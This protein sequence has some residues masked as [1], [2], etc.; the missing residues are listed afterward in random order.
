MRWGGW[1]WLGSPAKLWAA[2]IVF[3]ILGVLLAFGAVGGYAISKDSVTMDLDRPM[4]HIWNACVEETRHQGAVKRLD[5][6]NGRLDAQIQQAS[7]VV[8]VEQL[9]PATVRVVIR[10]R[11]NLLPRIEVAQ[12]LAI[13]IARRI[14]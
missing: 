14:G 4:E 9:T 8:T 2:S 5:P 12:R 1:I 7:V 13:G 3:V 10:A 6:K 11:R